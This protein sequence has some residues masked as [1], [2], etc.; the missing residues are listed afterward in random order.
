MLE[1]MF[2][3]PRVEAQ[4][5]LR[6]QGRWTY[7][8]WL[9]FPNDGWKYEIIDGVLYMT[10]PPAIRHQMSLLD[11]SSRM[12]LYAADHDLGQVLTAPCGVRLP[13][14]PVPADD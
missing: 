13:N 6:P 8:D 9:N 10:P 12:H 14:Q 7:E 5:H 2:D 4:S 3:R 1:K 11:L